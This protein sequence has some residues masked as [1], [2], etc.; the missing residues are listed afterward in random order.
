MEYKTWDPKEAEKSF[1]PIETK[2]FLDEAGTK[3]TK[4]WHENKGF[5]TD[6]DISEALG[7]EKSP[8][9]PVKVP[10]YPE[11]Q[12]PETDD[13]YVIFDSLLRSKIRPKVHKRLR[14]FV[15]TKS[16]EESKV[17]VIHIYDGNGGADN[18]HYNIQDT[19][20][21]LA[22]PSGASRLSTMI[23]NDYRRDILSRYL[24]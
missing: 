19:D 18:Y 12:P 9:K 16:E 20:K 2:K 22:E 4:M 17:T 5:I 10:H 3:L 23:L 6:S 14:V 21:Y 7:T 8:V 15:K 13:P 24:V 1:D 11:W